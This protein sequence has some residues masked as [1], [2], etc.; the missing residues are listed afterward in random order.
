MGSQ[1]PLPAR[2]VGFRLPRF[3]YVSKK[4]L[5]LGTKVNNIN[6]K[7]NKTQMYEFVAIKNG[8]ISETLR[9]HLL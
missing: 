7:N 8:V 9:S 1:A 6:R 3:I 4:D 2:V 5:L